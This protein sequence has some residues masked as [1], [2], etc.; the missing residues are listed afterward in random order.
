MAITLNGDTIGSKEIYSDPNFSNSA[1]DLINN[2]PGL[3]DPNTISG[4]GTF[5]DA[6]YTQGMSGNLNGQFG[7]LS[8][9]NTTT[10]NYTI[11][12][13]SGSSEFQKWYGNQKKLGNYGTNQ[14]FKGKSYKIEDSKDPNFG[15]DKVIEG[16]TS[17]KGIFNSPPTPDKP[18]VRG[19]AFSN[20]DRRQQVRGVKTGTA[21]IKRNTMK[22]ARNEAKSIKGKNIF[23]TLK[24]RKEHT[25]NA[26]INAKTKMTNDR[27][28]QFKTINNQR[29]LQ[30]EQGVNSSIGKKNRVILEKGQKGSPFTLAKFGAINLNKVDLVKK[31]K[32]DRAKAANSSFVS[33]DQ[34]VKNKKEGKEKAKKGGSGSTTF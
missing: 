24:L 4:T 25:K 31:G 32:E 18:E 17:Y 11:P 30:N 33:F 20:F 26:R 1:I 10:P 28:S 27:A 12:G 9:Q 23:E 2:A 22:A 6:G 34:F 13:F 16:K 19:D 21:A 3:G 7:S 15:K 5:Q 14:T 29:K 8:L